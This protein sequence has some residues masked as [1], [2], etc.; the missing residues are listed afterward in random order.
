MVEYGRALGGGDRHRARMLLRLLAALPRVNVLHA[1]EVLTLLEA[2]VQS[3]VSIA[4]A[5]APPGPRAS[6]QG[7]QST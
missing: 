4:Q 6:K 1:S 7:F 2:V 3:A 5:G